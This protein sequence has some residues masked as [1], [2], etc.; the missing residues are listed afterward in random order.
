[1]S[2]SLNKPINT[3]SPRSVLGSRSMATVAFSFAR[4]PSPGWMLHVGAGGALH[5]PH[6]RIPLVSAASAVTTVL[7]SNSFTPSHP[8]IFSSS[9]T[10]ARSFARRCPPRKRPADYDFSN[11]PPFTP[12]RVPAHPP[13]QRRHHL[14]P[15]QPP[16]LELPGR[17]R[18]G[19]R[20]PIHVVRLVRFPEGRRGH[21]DAHGGTA[22]GG[23]REKGQQAC[24]PH[25]FLGSHGFGRRQ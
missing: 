22:Q 12:P 6:Q 10:H 18:E 7:F 23:G 15:S 16:P 14:L 25:R 8:C 13:S 17:Q 21:E 11:H 24:G 5:S 20:A 2:Y 4:S 19:P 9:L 3:S 1:M